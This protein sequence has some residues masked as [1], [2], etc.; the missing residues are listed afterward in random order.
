MTEHNYVSGITVQKTTIL[1]FKRGLY[2]SRGVTPA[3]AV[4]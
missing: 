1:K 3:H 2:I 4:V